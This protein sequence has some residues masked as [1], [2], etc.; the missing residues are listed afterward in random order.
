ML[1]LRR[2]AVVAGN[3]CP[4][5]LQRA[6][7]A[8]A[9]VD[10]RFDGKHHPRLQLQAHP[11]LANVQHLRPFMHLLANAM[12]AILTYDAVARRFGMGLDGMADITQRSP[13]AYLFDAFP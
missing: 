5:I 6:R 10:H 13:G 1:P 7:P 12:P 3:H 2:Q 9:L 11:A 4:A 8:S